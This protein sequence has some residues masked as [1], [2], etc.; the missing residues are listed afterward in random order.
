MP[1]ISIVCPCFEQARMTEQFLNDIPL[2]IKSDY[3]VIII[4]NGS[5]QET[6]DLLKKYPEVVV[7][8][9]P[10]NRYVTE[11]W[12]T[13]ISIAR[14]EYVMV[15]NNDITFAEWID[16]ELIKHYDW[17]IQSPLLRQHGETKPVYYGHNINGTCWMIKKS[18]FHT[19]IPERLKIW[20]NDNWLFCTYG[21]NWVTSTEVE[22]WWSQTVNSFHHNPITDQDKEAFFNIMKENWWIDY[23]KANF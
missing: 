22:H 17:K 6:K 15:C 12:N 1:K 2:K 4:D 8:T 7:L 9:Y 14:W 21:T 18:D 23:Q 10:K 20:Y 19:P 16:I 5:S 11:A 3:E 13:W